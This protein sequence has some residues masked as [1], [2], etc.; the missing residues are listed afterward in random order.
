M[1]TAWLTCVA[2]SCAISVTARAADILSITVD[3]EDGTYTMYSDVWFEASPAK[4]FQVY[5]HWDYS[6]QFSRAI[7]EA[8]DMEPDTEGRPQFYVRNKGCVLFFC[9]SFVRQGY[10]EVEGQRVL[11][12]F[13]NPETSD[14]HL[15]NE[16]WT[17]VEK[18]GGTVVTY[19]LEMRPKFW[20]PPAIGPYFI[21]RK[22]K[23]SGGQA[24]DRIE[25]IA[26][27]IGS[28]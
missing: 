4:I 10:V 28:D 23:K 9:K 13:T 22:L 2:L 7:V 5:R 20:V 18:D 19:T 12:A 16:S 21:K 11:R 14:F 27:G 1:R 26:Q 25:D 6:T 15:S 8:R 17:F 3:N 24:V